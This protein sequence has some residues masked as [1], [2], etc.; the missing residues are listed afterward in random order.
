MKALATVGLRPG[1]PWQQAKP[2]DGAAEATGQ[3]D[4][5]DFNAAWLATAEPGLDIVWP[6]VGSYPNVPSTRVVTKHNPLRKVSLLVNGTE[7]DHLNFDGTTKNEEGTC[8]L[9]VWRGISLV[10]GDNRLEAVEYNAAGVET[11]RVV[12]T[13][14]YSGSPTAAIVVPERSQLIADGKQPVVVTVML[15]DKDGHPAREGMSG[16]FTVDPPYLP[17]QKAKDLQASPLLAP[18]TDRVRY[19]IGENGLANLELQPTGQSG[20]AVVHVALADGIHDYRVWVKP[21]DRDWILVGLAEG[22]V[23]YNTVTGNME[24]LKSSG[25][26]ERYYEDGRVAFYAKGMIKGEW[27]LTLAYDSAKAAP[28]GRPSLYQTVDPNKYYLLYGD[29][30]EQR[31]DAAS[32]KKVYVKLER[33]QFYA[34]FGDYDTG[35]TVTELSRYSRNFTG[36]KSEY[37]GDRVDATVFAADSNQAFVRDEIPGDGT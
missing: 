17:L 11:G 10:E 2:A 1:E 6:G 7:A 18:A 34:L 27:L 3:K 16:E 35:L 23:G 14:H 25:G 37:K 32:A 8:G 9:S 12:R 36:F 28:D 30:A 15:F 4:K 29:A 20:E 26:D 5:I 19:R 24:T 31:Y 13:V 33:N 21:E 22:T